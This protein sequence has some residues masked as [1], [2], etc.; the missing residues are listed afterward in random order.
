M[1]AILGVLGFFTLKI[2]DISL[3]HGP[4][5]TV[6]AIF[7]SVAGLD[8]KSTVRVAGVRKGKVTDVQLTGDGK[9]MVTMQVDGDVQLH[10]GATARIADLGLLGEKF[11][12]L[13]T[14]TPGTPIMAEKNGETMLS[15]SQ[16]PNISSVT[17]QVADIATDVKAITASLR[18]AIGGPTGEKR[19]DDIVENVRQITA[20]VRLL[21]AANQGNINASAENIR[22]ITDNL[23]VEIPKIAQSIDAL[24]GQM[25]G[26][27]GEN[28]QDL[29]AIIE[30]LRGLSADLRVTATNLNSI[31]GQVKSGEGTVGKLLY[32]DEAHDRLI[33]ALSSVES[34]V[35]EL[36]ST[37]GRVNKLQLDVG[38]NGE[39]QAGLPVDEDKP[40]FDTRSRS[41]VK[42]DL[43]PD[44]EKNRFYHIEAVSLPRGKQSERI[45]DT[46][47][48]NPVTG[49]TTRTIEDRTRFER[50]FA[51]SAQVGWKLDDVNLRL[52]LFESTGGI[53]ADYKVNDR[54]QV[55]GEAYDFGKARDPNP[56]LRVVGEYIF[57]K[58][59]PNFP[60][61]FVSTG[62][63]NPLNDTGFILGGGIRWS[64]TDLK[65]LL[66]SVPLK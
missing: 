58:Q 32:N 4:T 37:L 13:D 35:N 25:G 55:T 19:L 20:Q 57:R 15:G 3:R 52:G 10:Q 33:G 1:V 28:R 63:D 53:G 66:G 6:K 46:T 54:V 16:N 9:A 51:I 26:T 43:V 17:S 45:T 36:K 60:Q 39:Y 11:V 7:D 56:H 23:R 29:R 21:I 41:A 12:E 18:G 31:T 42:L 5:K 22:A 64:D 48:T 65:Y 2:E 24:A 38:L 61:L 14:G 27:V 50:S 59:K 47:I 40:G 30:N 62:V 34:G 49:E 44:P 8:E